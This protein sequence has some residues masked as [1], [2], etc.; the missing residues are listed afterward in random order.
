MKAKFITD[1][2]SPNRQAERTDKEDPKQARSNTETLHPPSRANARSDRLEPRWVADITDNLV[3][4]V[5][6]LSAPPKTENE[7]PNRMQQRNDIALPRLAKFMMDAL[8]PS[9]PADRTERTEP[10]T[11][12]D[13]TETDSPKRASPNRLKALPQRIW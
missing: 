9:L 6:S 13:N 2:D 5:K 3:W 12:K 7:L 1:N 11:A 8:V 4:R 10:T